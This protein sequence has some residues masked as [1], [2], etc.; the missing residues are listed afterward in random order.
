[1]SS[2]IQSTGEQRSE[3]NSQSI[4]HV[5]I[6]K[7]SKRKYTC[8]AKTDNA[9]KELV[10]QMIKASEEK[11]SNEMMDT[12]NEIVNELIDVSTT[13]EIVNEPV[14]EPVIESV[15]EPVNEK[16]DLTK[17]QSSQRIIPR[18]WVKWYPLIDAP[19]NTNCTYNSI[20]INK[21]N[22]QGSDAFNEYIT[23]DKY[24][25]PYF[26]FDHIES[27]EQYESVLKWLDS[28]V[29]EFGQYS[30][31]GYS[32][33]VQI[34]TSHNLKFIELAE[35]KVSIHVVFYEKR[36]LQADMMELVKKTANQNAKRN[37][38]PVLIAGK[39]CKQDDEPFNQI[40]QCTQDE[41][42]VSDVITNWPLVIHKVPSLKE[43]EKEK[44]NSKR[45]ADVDN[46]LAE[47]GADG[48]I[49]TKSKVK[50]VKIDD[51]DYD[52]NLIVFNKDQM[53]GLLKKFETTFENLQKTTASLRYSPHSEEFIKECYTECKAFR[54]NE[55]IFQEKNKEGC[56]NTFTGFAYK[57][58][59]TDD[60]T[61]IQ[62]FLDHIKN[63]LAGKIDTQ[64]N[65]EYIIK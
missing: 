29:S 4:K 16:I 34:C 18:F 21:F 43:Q 56:I 59:M 38:P 10:D 15:I 22:F 50:I 5:T 26:D 36:I 2:E 55:V 37:K 39:L 20:E 51:I 64:Q 8:K 17:Q 60:F 41:S 57:E 27:L 24:C 30:I 54:N 32:N 44:T 42:D 35:K 3:N 14:I 40:V 9:A 28:L 19:P 31:G 47:V 46:G 1:M 53:M 23:P 33:D 7:V 65:Y 12:V 45:L 61:L 6:E 52:D 62:P 63:V 58:I 11:Q 25:H 13:N 48:K 49:I